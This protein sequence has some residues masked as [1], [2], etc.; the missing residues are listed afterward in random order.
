[1]FLK[2]NFANIKKEIFNSKKKPNTEFNVNNG[3]ETVVED[4]LI[5]EITVY[6]NVVD[7]RENTIPVSQTLQSDRSVRTNL[8]L[9]NITNTLGNNA[10]IQSRKNPVKPRKGRATLLTSPEYRASLQL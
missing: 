7:L 6:Q 8:P 1:M 2:K 4:E 10:T 9:N 3:S 5:A